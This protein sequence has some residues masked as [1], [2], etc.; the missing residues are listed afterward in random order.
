MRKFKVTAMIEQIHVDNSVIPFMPAKYHL[1]QKVLINGDPGYIIGV[2]REKYSWSYLVV[3]GD[4]PSDDSNEDW[5][6]ESRVTTI[7]RVDHNH[8]A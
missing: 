8:T 5:H 1:G 4:P 7:T 6:S 2:Q 3:E